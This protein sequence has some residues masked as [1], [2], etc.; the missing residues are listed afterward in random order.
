M[1]QMEVAHAQEESRAVNREEKKYLVFTTGNERYCVPLLK[2]NEIIG[3]R[4]ITKLP[5]APSYVK[6]LLNLRGRIITVVDFSIIVGSQN[7][8]EDSMK[9]SIIISN[10]DD[11]TIGFLID[12]VVSVEGFSDSQI[13]YHVDEETSKKNIAA[14]GVAKDDKSDRLTLLVDLAKIIEANELRNL[15]Y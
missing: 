1:M 7:N 15:R 2:V 5:K 13:N 12:E 10:C 14:L 3:V 4:K 11:L 9:N 8:T 6:G